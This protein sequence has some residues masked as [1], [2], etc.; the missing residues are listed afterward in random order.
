MKR[1][2]IFVRG[3]FPTAIDAEWASLLITPALRKLIFI[4][5]RLP[6]LE[7]IVRNSLYWSC[8]SFAL[9][10]LAIDSASAQRI[11]I[12]QAATSD[13]FYQS[14]GSITGNPLTPVPQSRAQVAQAPSTTLGTPQFDPYST[15]PN[16][17]SQ[18]P[19]LSSPSPNSA[20]ST[21]T[22]PF[23]QTTP[24]NQGGYVQPNYAQP[25]YPQTPSPQYG[26]PTY[27]VPGP[28]YAP[29]GYGQ[30]P[31]VLFPNGLGLP[32]WNLPQA[33][34]G[35][36]LRLFQDVRMTYTWV[37]GGDS[38]DKLDTN[39]V[40]LATTV[41]FPNFLYSAAPLQVSPG[42][43]FHFWD[44]PTTDLAPN[45]PGPPLAPLTSAGGAFP[46]DL[47]SRVYSTYLDFGWA[48]MITPQFGADVDFNVGVF[49]D[50]DT[51]TTDS[52]RF[53]GTGLLVLGLTPTVALKG[54]VTYLDRL[55]IK[56]LP[57]GG[58]LWRPNQQT[59]FDI[60]FPKPKLAQY[61]TT[62]GN[63][64]VW[65]YVN[66]EIGGGSWTV[67][68]DEVVLTNL[69]GGRTVS[70]IG[71]DRRVDINDYRIGGGLEWTCQTGLRGFAEVAYVFQRELVFASGPIAKQDLADTF[72]LR[73]G[74]TY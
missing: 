56:L 11:Q 64:D 74:L 18:P 46:T 31:Q 34:P 47:P 12:P 7:A 71:G 42:F 52:V 70:Q 43:I 38:T 2:V 5:T 28:T 25:V 36:Y 33:Q 53:Q 60:Y 21:S 57:A 68:R 59:R 40:E 16:A 72:M 27:Q 35:Q 1:L 29:G 50:F 22:T 65:W 20:N 19:S 4:V 73:G 44:G 37:K 54:G 55:A 61:L 23:W 32:N 48:P 62:I 13:A 15:T 26:S 66:G 39:D 58:I 49:T 51:T 24:G 30:Q 3:K 17:A 45:S 41:N 69:V 63:T 10:V 14:Q 9:I 6:G 67:Q 8:W